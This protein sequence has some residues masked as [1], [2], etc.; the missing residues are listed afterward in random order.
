MPRL[1]LIHASS[2][3]RDPDLS[4]AELAVVVKHVGEVAARKLPVRVERTG[5]VTDVTCTL[6]PLSKAQATA[7]QTYLTR[8][9]ELPREFLEPYDLALLDAW[10]ES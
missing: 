9:S 7:L 4:S 2:T 5:D 3:I 10:A 8:L 6:L 1:S